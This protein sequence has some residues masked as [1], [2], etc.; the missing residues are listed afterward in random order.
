MIVDCPEHAHIL[1]SDIE[2][3]SRSARRISISTQTWHRWRLAAKDPLPAYRVC[4][5]WVASRSEVDAWIVRRSQRPA[6]AITSPAAS[7]ARRQR[8]I[9]AAIKE[10]AAKGC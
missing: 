4:G 6:I 3:A 7:P 5:R 10:C 1:P 2:L 9:D 8:Q